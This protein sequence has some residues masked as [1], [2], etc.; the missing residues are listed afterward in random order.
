ML[1]HVPLLEVLKAPCDVVAQ[2]S[3]RPATTRF[4]R[5]RE[6]HLR[7]RQSVED[8]VRGAALSSPSSVGRHG[9]LTAGTRQGAKGVSLGV[10]LPGAAHERAR[11]L[12]R[13]QL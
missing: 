9:Q 11:W 10:M 8:A 3:G 13:M 1:Q 4:P 5:L 6:L 12:V 2:P 7:E